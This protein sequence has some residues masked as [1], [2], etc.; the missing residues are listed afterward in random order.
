MIDYRD[1]DEEVPD[2]MGW[3]PIVVRRP[4]YDEAMKLVE[5]THG[6]DDGPDFEAARGIAE[7]CRLSGETEKAAFWTE[8]EEYLEWRVSVRE[9]VETIILEKGERWNKKTRKK[10]KRRA[11]RRRSGKGT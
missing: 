3:G 10:V 11:G 7:D 6:N 8:V 9:G 2:D 1:D 5:G 4:V